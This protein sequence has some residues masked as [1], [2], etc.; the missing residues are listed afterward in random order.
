MAKIRVHELAKEMGLN[1]R[2][3]VN[4]L[5]DLGIQVKNHFSTLE[6]TEVARIKSYA[7]KQTPVLEKAEAVVKKNDPALS[8]QGLLTT[9]SLGVKNAESEKN[10]KRPDNQNTAAQPQDKRGFERKPVSRT[11]GS[12]KTSERP[13]GRE[14]DRSGAQ[15]SYPSGTDRRGHRPDQRA[16]KSEGQPIRP[17][18]LDGPSR[19]DG[20]IQDSGHRPVANT[21]PRKDRVP[22][23]R[24][25]ERNFGRPEH[26]SVDRRPIQ[27]RPSSDRPMNRLQGDRSPMNRPQGD[28]LAMNRPQG[29]RPPMNRPQGDRSLTGRPQGDRPGGRPGDRSGGRPGDRATGRPV[30]QGVAGSKPIVTSSAISTKPSSRTIDRDK[31]KVLGDSLPGRGAKKS[32]SSK[33]TDLKKAP[34]RP[35]TGRDKFDV[36]RIIEDDH[37]DLGRGRKKTGRHGGKAAAKNKASQS[38]TAPSLPKLVTIG[39]AVTVQDLASALNKTAAEIIKRLMAMG[40]MV[41]A[42][43]TIDFDTAALVC[44]ELGVDAKPEIT[45][46]EALLRDIVDDPTAQV[47]RPPVVTVMGHVDH[48]KTSLLD[49]IRRTKVTENEAGGITQHIGA[50]QVEVNGKKISFIDTPGHEAFT[51]MRARGAQVTDIAILVVAADDGVMPQT[52]EAINH[53]KAANVPII[54]AINKIDKPTAN[55]DRI[56][57]QLTEYGLL[58]EDWGGDTICVPVSAHTREGL[59]TLLEMILLVAEMTE[60]KANPDRNAK[61]TVIEAQLDK[62]RGPVAT[63]LVQHGTL[64][65]GDSILVGL[66][67]GKVRAMVDHRGEWLKEAT[68][69]TP[70]EVLGLDEVPMAGDIF[71]VVSE[72]KI[73]RQITETRQDQR[74]EEEMHKMTRVTLDDLFKQIKEGQIKELNLIIKGDVQ[75]SI[76]ALRQSLEKLS[77]DEVRVNLVHTGVGTITESD[78]MLAS[79]SNAIIIGFNVRP[80]QNTRRAAEQEQVDIRLY[81]VI[82]EAVDDIRAAMSGL[83]DPDW[84]EVVLG[85]AEVRATFKVPKV[86]IIAGSYVLEGKILKGAE[87]RVIRNG[88]V[89]QD[90]KIDSL[91][92]FKDDV[93]EVAQGYECGIG[94]ENFHDLKEG[95]AIEAYIMEKVERSL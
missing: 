55:P 79:A 62:G 84:K 49:A 56:K 57:Q 68:P 52:I 40:V 82:Y 22:G 92:R 75:G 88:I 91:R 74:R 85:R 26:G 28:R 8:Q 43:Q 20:H 2:D 80:D 64:R 81:R 38:I 23:P 24:N 18:Q 76:E 63:M 58:A 12:R 54:V 39:K 34:V 13:G 93:K 14:P 15:P 50:Y 21:G 9:N 4:R 17:S 46:E 36:H 67:Y 35:L 33:K 19:S 70:V 41:T 94:L 27:G 59:D 87:A 29:D 73:A 72:E 65:V 60:F 61:G 37:L 10:N 6:E 53:A 89:V 51:A 1:S 16:F 42:T 78:V 32:I 7:L 31:A 5:L 45:Q 77:T 66:T 30:G 47:E 11:D 86:G 71:Q 3:L 90:S 25:G 48:G 44:S 95:D 69:S 83:L